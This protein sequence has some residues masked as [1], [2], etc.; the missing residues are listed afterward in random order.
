VYALALH[1]RCRFEQDEHEPLDDDGRTFL[2][3]SHMQRLLWNVGA[4]SG[5]KAA[6]T[7]LRWLCFGG[8]LEDT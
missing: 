5:E 3:V 7:A 4:N 1:L 6:V 2:T 8:I